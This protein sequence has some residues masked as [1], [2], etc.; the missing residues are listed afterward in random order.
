[1][2]LLALSYK[3]AEL[4]VAYPIM[5]GT[6]P[7]ISALGASMLLGE[8]ASLGGWIGILLISCGVVL[9]CGESMGYGLINRRSLRFALINAGIIVIYTLIDGVGARLSAHP[10]SYTGWM[11]LFTAAILACIS[12]IRPGNMPQKYLKINWAKSITGGLF[13]LSSYGLALWAM[14]RAPIAPVA[15][16]RESSV[17]FAALIAV[18]VLKEKI[19]LIRFLSIALVFSGA[20]II[21]I[22]F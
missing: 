8:S 15:A 10:F 9:L 3:D 11:F 1:F 5:R 2:C 19:G 14:T 21:K 20:V 6:P 17:V 16:L 13:T 4:S 18:F 22:S 7:A 12:C